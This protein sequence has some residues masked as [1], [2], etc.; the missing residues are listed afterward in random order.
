MSA[1][2]DLRPSAFSDSTLGGLADLPEQIGKY[3]VLRRL[4]E[5]ATSDVFLAMDDFKGQEVAIKR[6]RTWSAGGRHRGRHA[7]HPLLRR[8][9]R[10]GRPAAAPRTSCR[11]W[12]PCRTATCR[13]SSWSSSTASR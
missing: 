8:R 9:G 2:D 10:A 7:Q 5:G 3:R 11:S 1:S 6:M 13:I 4:G 12:T